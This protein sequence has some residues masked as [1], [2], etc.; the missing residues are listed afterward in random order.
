MNEVAVRLPG[1]VFGLLGSVTTAFLGIAL[2]GRRAGI[3]A[4]FFHATLVLPIALAQAAVQ[5][6]RSSLD[7]SGDSLPLASMYWTCLQ[8]RRFRSRR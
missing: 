2:F 7:Q 4:G 3:L 1:L 5:T 6:W 8:T